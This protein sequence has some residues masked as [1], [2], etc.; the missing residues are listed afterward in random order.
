MG[1]INGPGLSAPDVPSDM[2]TEKIGNELPP[3]LDETPPRVPASL[4]ASAAASFSGYSP[5]FVDAQYSLAAQLGE[6]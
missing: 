3:A 5:R 1:S 2:P 6:I 4:L